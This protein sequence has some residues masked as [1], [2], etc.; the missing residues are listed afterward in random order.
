MRPPR[1]GKLLR[2]SGIGVGIICEGIGW[3]ADEIYQVGVG[4]NHQETDVLSE[5]W[6]GVKFYGCDPRPCKDYPGIF[7][8]VA[9]TDKVGQAR[10]YVKPRH[11]DGSS[12][13]PTPIATRDGLQPM[14]REVQTDT[15]DNLFP[16][17]QGQH[18]LLWL[19]CEGSELAAL[20]SGDNLLGKAEVVN[21]EMTFG[22]KTAKGKYLAVEIYRH[23]VRCGF[24]MLDNHTQRLQ[25]GQCDYVYV[26]S[27]LFR[28]D[29]CLSPQELDRWDLLTGQGRV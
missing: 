23:L 16:D 3:K 29:R 15:L 8:Q 10:L 26:R 21:V 24:W 13:Y 27:Y 28:P 14:M 18:I 22:P 4:D 5:A 12:L 20:Q 7:H 6:A 17:P 19:D 9:V 11:H 25:E 1:K 2:R